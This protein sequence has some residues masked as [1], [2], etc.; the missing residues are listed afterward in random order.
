MTR[1]E[2]AKRT[3]KKQLP[4]EEKSKPSWE[5]WRMCVKE[6]GPGLLLVHRERLT[7]VELTPLPFSGP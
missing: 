2:A 5:R 4:Q 7:P 1:E 3:E 6:G